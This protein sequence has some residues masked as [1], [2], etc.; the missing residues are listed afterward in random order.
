MRLEDRGDLKCCA[1]WLRQEPLGALTA[2]SYIN[3]LR[4]LIRLTLTMD[5]GSLSPPAFHDFVHQKE[6][7]PHPPALAGS[8]A[9]EARAATAFT[10]GKLGTPNHPG[11]ANRGPC[12]HV[13]KF[14][15]GKI[16]IYS[17]EIRTILFHAPLKR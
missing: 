2:L 17:S 14:L 1:P 8:R 10:G 7:A 3:V 9:R 12:Q 13:E 16:T 4:L 15:R 6:E 5:C 11:L